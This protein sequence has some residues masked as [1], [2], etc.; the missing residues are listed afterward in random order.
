MSLRKNPPNPKHR[1]FGPIFFL[2][3]LFNFQSQ[4]G[5]K[6]LG[7]TREKTLEPHQF[8]F[9]QSTQPNIP[10]TLFPSLFHSFLKS[11]NEILMNLFSL[12]NY[13]LLLFQL[14]PNTLSF[15]FFG[16]K[17]LEKRVKARVGVAQVTEE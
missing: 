1:F 13:F 17:N 6:N 8:S 2:V 7:G 11:T 16:L 10:I 15:S 12:N 5:R 9:N 4:F 3:F 14:P